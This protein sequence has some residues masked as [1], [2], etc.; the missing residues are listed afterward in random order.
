[1][2]DRH[3]IVIPETFFGKASWIPFINTPVDS[4][5]PSEIARVNHIFFK[6]HAAESRMASYS[7]P[8][9]LDTNHPQLPSTHGYLKTFVSL[10]VLGYVLFYYI[11]PGMYD[12]ICSVPE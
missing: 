9:S 7:F 12:T 4:L 1:M 6:T 11:L 5:Q 3:S 10:Y 8:S 2:D